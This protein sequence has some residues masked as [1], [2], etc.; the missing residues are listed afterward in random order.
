M[1]ASSSHLTGD[2]ISIALPQMRSDGRRD[3]D[4]RITASD[5]AGRFAF[6]SCAPDA[7]F[8]AGLDD[9]RSMPVPIAEHVKLVLE[10]TRRVSGKVELGQ[11]PATRVY[12]T[13]ELGDDLLTDVSLLAPVAPDGSFTVAGVPRRALRI[14]PVVRGGE[15]GDRFAP[16]P[17]P[18]S[19]GP[20][21]GIS[22]GVA[23]PSR[24]LDVV[25]RSAMAAPIEGAQVVLVTGKRTIRS[26]G[27]LARAGRMGLSSR[28]AKPVA[29]EDVPRA[30]LDKIRPG[31]LV[32]HIEHA[33]P[34]ELTVCAVSFSGDLLDPDFWSRLQAHKAELAL[35]CE[36]IGPTTA[37]VE[38]AAPPQPSF[39]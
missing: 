29:G 10:P 23:L 20:T 25:V 30:V 6:E 36:P 35:K 13:I 12:V 5:A 32:A 26:L 39:E 14:G 19:T 11:L 33:E 37:I 1:V 17:L 4:L 21:A 22:L 8:V 3:E 24:V 27:D 9:R 31:D 7:A 34:G 38:L 16:Q 15:N 2:A 28:L 18:A